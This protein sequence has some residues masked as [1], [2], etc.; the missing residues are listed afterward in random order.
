MTAKRHHYIP[1]CYLKGF[2]DNPNKP[3]LHVT[4]LAERRTFITKPGNIGAAQ[5]F[6]GINV[7][8]LPPDALE[9]SLAGFESEL[10]PALERIIAQRSITDENDRSYLLNLMC[11]IAVKNPRHRSNFGRF[12]EQ[13]LKRTMELATATPELFASQI[14]RAKAD[15]FIE[16]DA[17]IDYERMRKFI[18]GDQY[19][20]VTMTDYHL[21]LEL[22]AFDNVL[23]Y[24]FQRRWMLLR[25]PTGRTGFITSDHPVC[26]MWSEP[27]QRKRFHSPGH[28]LRRTQIV[29]PISNELAVRALSKC[30]RFV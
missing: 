14:R 26:L 30:K 16:P 23:P 18:D 13:I 11:L 19:R 27:A 6:H 29:F 25:A 2:A 17:H 9:N 24:F 15:G 20:I 8:G 28:V 7:Y 3:R 12:H 1:Q 21:G 22:K 5:H 4:D 10:A